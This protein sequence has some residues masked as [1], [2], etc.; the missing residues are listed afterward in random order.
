MKEKMQ[1]FGKAMLVP[2]S[3]VAIGGLL[4][5][6]GSAFTNQDTVQALGFN[7]STYQ[8]SF[9]FNAFNALKSL[10]DSIFSNLGVLYAVGVTFSLAKREKGWAAFSALVAFL[11]V[12]ATI[13]TFIAADGNTAIN[14]TVE[15]LTN[16]GMTALEASKKSALFTTELGYFTYK[17]GVFGGII[18]GLCVSFIHN[19]FY[20]TK[21]PTALA[22]FSGTRS[23]PILSLLF[24]GVMGMIMYF[25]WP[26]IGGLFVN[27]S[28]FVAKSGL[29]GTFIYRIVYESLVPFG[30][31]PLLSL[32][33]HWTEL[34]GSMMV[35]GK[36]VVGNSAIQLAQLA[37]PDHNKLLV[38]AFMGGYGIIDYA[39]FPAMGLAMY[40]TALPQ[41]KKKIAG[42]LIPSIVSCVLFGITEPILFTFLFIAPW[43]YFLVY[44]PLA[45]LGEVLAEFFKVSVYQGN[46][47]DLIPFLL[48]PEKLNLVPYL[49]LLPIFFIAT[50]YIVK[51]LILKLNVLTPG[52]EEDEETVR[53]YSKKDLEKNAKNF[54]AE[55]SQPVATGETL[56]QG[57]IRGLGGAE[58]IEEVDNCISRL[59]VI[60]KNPDLVVSDEEWKQKLQALGVIRLNKGIQIVYGA[61]VSSVAVDVKEELGVD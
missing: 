47:K 59:R 21:L 39:I 26:T 8:H 38:R 48:R 27:I 4:L 52:R 49:F 58:N 50:Y 14:T 44:V 51:F 12:Q 10:G 61:K 37:S 53:L 34:G 60:V 17:M 55:K 20:K 31:H 24:G 3:L 29:V 33:I 46:I 41:N 19:K 9:G 40:K 32:P 54:E 22:F 30:M 42:L 57:I 23:V 5:G 13:S 16:H 2:I 18:I 7:W 11:A 1:S 36:L 43:L 25:V 56:S 45:G 28:Q 6:L 35:D 15:Y